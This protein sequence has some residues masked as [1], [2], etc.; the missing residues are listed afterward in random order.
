MAFVGEAVLTAFIETLCAKLASSDLLRFAR[1]EEIF[2]DIKKWEKT[3]LKLH[4]VL[5][6]AEEKQLTS[7]LVKLWLDD[8]RDL[9]Y[10]VED[11]L[12]EFATEAFYE[13]RVCGRETDKAAILKLLFDEY[14]EPIINS[15]DF[16]A[17]RV[18]A[19]I[20][21]GGLGKT[22][23][24]Q[25][26][27]NDKEAQTH[28]D[29]RVW[30]CV[31]DDFNV[32]KLTK[33]IL[34]Y[35][36]PSDVKD[37]NQLD[38][39]QLQL[40]L[41]EQLSRK[42]FLLVLD[43]VW[44][45]NRRVWEI[46]YHP[47]MRSG[48]AQGSR[49]IV[50]TRNQGVVSAIGATSTYPL[51]GLSDDECLSLFAQQALGTRNFD[52][53]PELRVV[54]GKI[55]EKCK[56]LPLAAK[57]LGGML[58]TNQNLD[59]WQDILESKIW[60]LPDQENND[61]LPALQLSY[62]HL[63]SPLKRCF[64][65]CSIFP[66]DYVF[67][68]DELVLLWMGEGFL[69]QVKRKKRMEEIG[70]EF[71][72]E[73]LAR[74]FFQHSDRISSQFVM[75][76]LI[77]DLAQFV[78]GDT[79]F[80]LED[81]LENNEQHAI[82]ERARHSS[83]IRQK[84]A[85]AGKFEVFG[86][87]KTN[88]RTL[89]SLPRNI[90][91]SWEKGYISQKVLNDLLIGMRCLRVLSL[92]GYYTR[93]VPD[94]ISELKHLRY[95]NFSN[96]S[97]K[98]LP[99]SVGDLYN[100]QTL[101]LHGCDEL[102]K[103]PKG[104]GKLINLRHLDITGT[105]K[106][107]EMSFQVGNLS[108][109]QTLSRFIV[110]KSG[111]PG[112]GELKNLSDLQGVL[113][114]SK[115]HEIVKVE[116]ASGANLKNKQKL[117]ELELEWNDEF[118]DSRN[119]ADELQVLE[120]L[121]PHENLE[122]LTVAFYGGSKFPCWIGDPFS[123]MVNLTLRGCKKCTSLPTLGG[124]PLLKVLHIEGMGKVKSIGDEFYGECKNPFASLKELQF[125]DMPEW[126]SW[127]HSNLMKENIRAFHN[128]EKFVIIDC[129]KLVCGLPGMGH[130]RYLV[131][132]QELVISNCGGLTCLW[133]EEGQ[134]V[135]CNLKIL[136]ISDCAE[137]EK[138]PSVMHLENLDIDGCPK[139]ESFP[140]TGLPPMLRH[141]SVLSC[142]NLKGL[143]Q[144]YNLCALESL[145]I[146]DC[147]SLRC[148]PNGEIPTTLKE[149]RIL[150]C[151]NLESLP[152][153]MGMMRHNSNSNST[154]SLEYLDISECPSLKSFSTATC[155]FVLPS[156]LKLLEIS[157]CSNLE[158]MSENMCPNN[159]ALEYL[160]LSK[161]P[162]LRT[163]PECLNSLKQL[164][165]WNCKGLEC[166]PSRG[167]ST[168]NLTLLHIYKC[169]N[170]EYMSS[171]MRNLKSLEDLRMRHCPGVKSFSE[172]DF[173]PNLTSLDVGWCENLKTPISEWGLQSLTSL[174]SL[175]IDGMFRDM[176][177]FPDDKCLLPSS[178]TAL[179]ISGMPSLTSLP[180]PKLHSLTSLRVSEM[181]SL[182]SLPLPKLHSLTSLQVGKMESLASMPLPKLDSLNSLQ[183]REM[184][185]LPSLPLQNLTSLQSLRISS[186]PK[187]HS[188]G[189]LPS[190]LENLEILD[191]PII[192]K[193]CL[194]GK[195]L[196]FPNIAYIPCIRIDR[197]D[198]SMD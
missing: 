145:T 142:G 99:D 73:L 89:I 190:T 148:F 85:V 128:L 173:P 90:S 4:A 111:G 106:L 154:C 158:S 194:K 54:G 83:F 160:R 115:L 40:K 153:G 23:L 114:I 116:D 172:G 188:L 24:A 107:H 74:S 47:I 167:L 191:C 189:L 150:D 60:N 184:K 42:K 52:D 168:S 51:E 75:H 69:H 159:T 82:P 180:L 77:H 179:T 192:K 18:I 76:D 109:L 177:S 41:K 46:F 25:L 141:L 71:F 12:D 49:V 20:G 135:L 36:V 140:E 21:M 44:N 22:T 101:I 133:E 81:K 196:Y 94:L 100:L 156:T 65:Y 93:E 124:L 53:Y 6:D 8:L 63:P 175:T 59:A 169:Q 62:H 45:E 79:C 38:L 39:N 19:I 55:A 162:N 29:L 103:L 178:L 37:L 129:P 91:L 122:R 97:I 185:S 48:G 30:V 163:L 1:Q 166:F 96:C 88:L 27:F 10:D 138:L 14:H 87:V 197:E 67:K 164:T 33:T 56:G 11:I 32:L 95:L 131:G 78:A 119:D 16:D 181:E 110:D 127:S 13:S 137:L 58:R 84:Y 195:G 9:A 102:I 117:E 187:L 112:I 144:N 92:A 28:F 3:L 43:D 126:E 198:I 147:P 134:G 80:N 31:S 105:W 57:T 113:S 125:V 139:L 170:L 151:Y 17:V 186:C 35:S 108:N 120:S 72:H 50:T 152:E 130:K 132:L 64:A 5:V 7:R 182:A 193:R 98:R 174:S 123:K 70:L 143:P 34:Q 68:V 136:R 61:I 157:R 171:E 66:K 146:F 161:Y 121:R 26:A 176:V 2:A 104:I 149:L 15:D 183:V 86:E 155:E 118:W 165:I